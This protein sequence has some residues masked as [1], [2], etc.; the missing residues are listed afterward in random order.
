M[1]CRPAVVRR[2]NRYVRLGQRVSARWRTGRDGEGRKGGSRCPGRARPADR[3]RAARHSFGAPP[4]ECPKRTRPDTLGVR[5]DRRAARSRPAVWRAPRRGWPRRPRRCAFP[6]VREV[7]LVRFG[8]RRVRRVVPVLSGGEAAARAVPG[9]GDLR[10]AG[11]AGL[12]LVP[13]GAPEGDAQPGRG[14]ATLGLAHRP[15]PDPASSDRVAT[16]HGRNSLRNGAAKRVGVS[17][18][19]ERLSLRK[20]QRASSRWSYTPPTDASPMIGRACGRVPYMGPY[21][22]NVLA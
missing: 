17:L 22:R 5:P 18:R 11:E 3:C 6:Y 16:C 1:S 10:V 7:R 12:R 19:C 14:L 20:A 15:R 21:V 9:I 4:N 13:V 8:A 2:N